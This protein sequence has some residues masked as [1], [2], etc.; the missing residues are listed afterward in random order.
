MQ[1][2]KI[3]TAEHAETAE[4]FLQKDKNKNHFI[5]ISSSLR[6]PVSLRFVLLFSFWD[7]EIFF[8][9][10]PLRMKTGG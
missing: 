7:I 8:S 9:L 4:G 10:Y 5:H 1:V 6:A 3:L 2:K